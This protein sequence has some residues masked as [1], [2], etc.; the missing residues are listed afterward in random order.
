MKT[1]PVKCSLVTLQLWDTV[2]QERFRSVTEQYYRKADGILAMY[3]VTDPASFTAVQAWIGSIKE[4]MCSGVVLMILGNKLDLSSGEDSAVRAEEG[5]RLA[6]HHKA[7]F[8]QCSA[9]TGLNLNESMS[10]MAEYVP[11]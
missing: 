8:Y 5:H 2:G 6:Q 3:D 1:F 9:K 11:L 4:K 10:H 7:L